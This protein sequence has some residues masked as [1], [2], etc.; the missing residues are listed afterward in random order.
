MAVLSQPA[1]SPATR[2]PRTLAE[3]DYDPAM[4][5]ML[6]LRDEMQASEAAFRQR[7]RDALEPHIKAEFINGEIILDSP[8][9]MEHTDSLGLLFQLVNVYVGTTKDGGKVQF[10][11]ALVT[12]RRNDVEPDLCY[13]RPE[14]ASGFDPEQYKFPPPDWV[15]EVLSPSTERRDRT[16][17]YVSY[18][19]A[20]VGEY[21]LLDA[22]IRRLEI[23]RLDEGKYVEAARVS[24]Q[25]AP[26]G[27]ALLPQLQFP[28]RACFEMEANLD[29]LFQMRPK[30]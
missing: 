13:W 26:V 19:A 25:D 17:K 3:R 20:G 28:L 27:P 15:V 7:F 1:E 23:Y 21:W 16:E 4:E 5:K 2:E 30:S 9:R 22:N 10:E 29:A 11:K 18:Q 12:L 14:K 24:E 6:A 8:A